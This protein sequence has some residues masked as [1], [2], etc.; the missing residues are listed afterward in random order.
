[1]ERFYQ[2]KVEL[3]KCLTHRH[4]DGQG[5]IGT[6]PCIRLNYRIAGLINIKVEISDDI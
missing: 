4:W 5:V 1:M 3:Y 6:D 2:T